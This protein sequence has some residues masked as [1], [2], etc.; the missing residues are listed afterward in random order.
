MKADAC[1][2]GSMTKGRTTR[3][4]GSFGKNVWRTSVTTNAE[5]LHLHVGVESR[6][7]I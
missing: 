7:F 4:P 1:K 3:P 5:R 2:H 6:L